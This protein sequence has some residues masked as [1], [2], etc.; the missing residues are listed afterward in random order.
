MIA[1]TGASGCLLY[2]DEHGEEPPD[3]AFDDVPAADSA[4]APLRNPHQLTCES[5]GGGEPCDLA[6][7]PCPQTDSREA[8]APIP[9][10]GVCFST[11][12][13]VDEKTCEERSDCRVVRDARCAISGMCP[14]FMGCFPT[15][16]F[17][18]P[19]TDCLRASDGETCSRSAEC[20]AFHRN[21]PCPLDAECPRPFAL[22]MPEGSSP[23]RCFDQAVC[24]APQPA[25]PAGTTAGVI[26]GC[27]SGVCIPNDLCELINA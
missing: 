18:D 1:L 11:C 8:L 23:G 13:G 6:C 22:C 3:C 16:N 12:E 2:F 17:V 25:C 4:P 15:D 9:S 10:W 19:A 5:F 26:N 24:G 20:T 14:S 27:F 7:G 21:E